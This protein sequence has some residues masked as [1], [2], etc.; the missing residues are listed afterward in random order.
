AIAAAVTAVILPQTAASPG[1]NPGVPPTVPVRSVDAVPRPSSS[2]ERHRAKKATWAAADTGLSGDSCDAST[3]WVCTPGFHVVREAK[4][5]TDAEMTI[6]SVDTRGGQQPLEV[7]SPARHEAERLGV[8][9]HALPAACPLVWTDCGRSHFS[10]LVVE[11]PVLGRE[12][13]GS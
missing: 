7:Q 13:A 4:P 1:L 6:C 3:S 2:A 5:T 12:A 9:A 10:A 11:L 8:A